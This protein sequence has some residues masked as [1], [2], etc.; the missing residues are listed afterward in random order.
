MSLTPLLAPD[1]PLCK[2][3][4]RT[5]GQADWE[6]L[7]LFDYLIS[8]ETGKLAGRSEPVGP[9]PLPHQELLGLSCSFPMCETSGGRYYLMEL[10]GELLMTMM[11]S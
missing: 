1:Q 4:G 11:A 6:L 5:P 2:A 7:L 3:R 8:E 10:F 9:Q